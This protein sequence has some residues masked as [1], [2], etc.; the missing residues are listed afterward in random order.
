VR[1]S[2]KEEG[3]ESIQP[4]NMEPPRPTGPPSKSKSGRP[5]L[6]NLGADKE[7][8]DYPKT[9]EDEGAGKSYPCKPTEKVQVDFLS[10]PIQKDRLQD[11]V[12]GIRFYLPSNGGDGNDK[13]R[14][15]NQDTRSRETRIP[16]HKKIKARAGGPYLC[17][18]DSD[19]TVPISMVEELETVEDWEDVEE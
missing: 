16:V 5:F 8:S 14:G 11:L 9:P 1:G 7:L 17:D 4:S 2:A 15:D 19:V 12:E 6:S 18:S 10:M 3:T 13:R